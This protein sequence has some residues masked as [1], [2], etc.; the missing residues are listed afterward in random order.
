MLQFRELSVFSLSSK[1]SSSRIPEGQFWQ[2]NVSVQDR[3][4]IVI[5]LLLTLASAYMCV[6]ESDLAYE[7]PMAASRKEEVSVTRDKQKSLSLM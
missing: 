6:V 1:I 2:T 3:K 7:L 5:V 4:F